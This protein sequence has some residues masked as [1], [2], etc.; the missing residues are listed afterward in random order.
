[1]T[2]PFTDSLT[3][4]RPNR[5]AR[6]PQAEALEGRLLLTAGDLD[7]SFST[8]GYVLTYSPALSKKGTPPGDRA[9]A[10]A[11][12][13]D[14]KI[15]AGGDRGLG[16]EAVRYNADG[17]LDEGS[18]N[19]TTPG[20]SF[21]AGG[22]AMP[23]MDV[24]GNDMALDSQGRILMTGYVTTTV[25]RKQ[26][27]MDVAL[28]RLLSNGA[29]DPSFGPNHDGKVVTDASGRGLD[30]EGHDVVTQPDGKIVVVGNTG[31][32]DNNG[33][34]VILRYNADGSLDDG[35][36][37]DTTPGDS[38][39]VGGKV[40]STLVPDRFDRFNGVALQDGKIVVSAASALPDGSN[41]NGRFLA[42]YNAN[43]T[44]DT[45]FGSGGRV[46]LPFIMPTSGYHDHPISIQSD[47]AIVSVGTNFNGTD[48]DV[49]VARVTPAGA[50]DTTFGAV[51]GAART[52]SV[53]IPHP[54]YDIGMSVKVQ[55]DGKLVVVGPAA[56]DSLVARLMPDGTLDPGFGSGGIVVHSFSSGSDDYL[57]DV[58][59]QGDGKLVAA[60]Y[61]TPPGLTTPAF[62]VARF[63]G[64]SAP[65]QAP[66]AVP[67]RTTSPILGSSRL[68]GT[69]LA[70][71][72]APAASTG[73]QEVL[74]L[75]PWMPSADQDLTAL[76]AEWLRAGRKRSR[77]SSLS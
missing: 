25:S 18:A 19:D 74:T 39:G 24:Q 7:T 33:D 66:S 44:L 40:V 72:S 15:L 75:N 43:G 55:A 57:L 52:G 61:A 6:R 51:S 71:A 59:V 9:Y 22:R 12:Q 62:L 63:L 29:L 11:I 67:Q 26:S 34:G 69:L 1:M 37:N 14:G 42:R 4:R 23:L 5:T 65:L 53:V 17:S 47:G 32:F 36:A 70:P 8:V 56:Q 2:R 50:L 41:R 16:F 20:D 38:F 28:I 31:G 10:V 45:G 13:S 64:A 76:A 49:A 35:S 48:Y 30:D 58:A 21:G 60:G 73:P 77:S 3:T 27:N 54:G 46:D 68:Q